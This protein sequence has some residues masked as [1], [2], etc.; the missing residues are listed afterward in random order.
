MY[1]VGR[2]HIANKSALPRKTKTYTRL[3]CLYS[4]LK[5]HI[6]NLVNICKILVFY[7]EFF[8]F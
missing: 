1:V 3:N 2:T 7:D 4:V 5:Q 8:K 6:V